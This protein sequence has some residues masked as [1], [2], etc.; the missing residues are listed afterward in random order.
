M[1]GEI[2]AGEI[3]EE[4]GRVLA[5]VP[6]AR[7]HQLRRLLEHLVD[8]TLEG[9]QDRLKESLLGIEVFDRGEGFDPRADP[10]VRIDARRLR[11]RLEQYYGDQGRSDP[12]RIV[13]E[14]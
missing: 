4:L 5:S 7:A 2:P 10:I 13:L 3:R 12:I 1:I 14:P 9:E 6:F 11:G 8:C